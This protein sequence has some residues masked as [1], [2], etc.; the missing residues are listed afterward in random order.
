VSLPPSLRP[1]DSGGCPGVSVMRPFETGRR[2]ILILDPTRY[3]ATTHRDTGIQPT[4]TI[5]DP[6]RDLASI[7]TRGRETV[8]SPY[9]LRRGGAASNHIQFNSIQFNSIQFNSIRRPPSRGAIEASHRIGL[10]R[11][12]ITSQPSTENLRCRRPSPNK[13]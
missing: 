4:T 11:I 5:V 8:R 1:F 7:A 12:V 13:R 2:K 6:S 9:L 10:C 3:D